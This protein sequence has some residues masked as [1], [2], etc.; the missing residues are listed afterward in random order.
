MKATELTGYYLEW[1]VAKC[2]GWNP[3]LE[4]LCDWTS[5][6]GCPMN[7]W[8]FG[9][10]IIDR[11]KFIF[12]PRQERRGGGVWASYPSLNGV[13]GD[14]YLIAAMR[15]YVQRKLGDEIDIPQL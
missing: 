4:P 10:P 9:G 5:R 12:T 14:T 2:E 7:N 1:A 6:E 3:I 13:W 11:E 15:C 8:S